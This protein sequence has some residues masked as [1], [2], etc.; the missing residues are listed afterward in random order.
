[1]T[2][3][4]GLSQQQMM[5]IGCNEDPGV[6]IGGYLVMQVLIRAMMPL[7]LITMMLMTPATEDLRA[8]GEPFQAS[9]VK[10]CLFHQPPFFIYFF[11]S[12]RLERFLVVSSKFRPTMH[13][14]S[15]HGTLSVMFLSKD[16]EVRCLVM[17][18]RGGHPFG[19]LPHPTKRNLSHLTKTV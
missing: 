18:P 7:P 9:K 2:S 12:R 15:R 13:T 17:L 3:V 16:G 10:L 8:Q 11:I 1:M 4:A 19:F 5:V 14:T 6:A